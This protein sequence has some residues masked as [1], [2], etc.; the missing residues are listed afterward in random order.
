MKLRILP[1]AKQDLRRGFRFYE[2]KEEGVGSY[3]LDTAYSDIDSIGL[4]AG[5]H[6]KVGVLF[7]FKSKRFPFWIYYRRLTLHTWLPYL[8]RVKRPGRSGDERRSNKSVD[9]TGARHS[10]YGVTGNVAVVSAGWSPLP[11]PV[12]HFY[13][14]PTER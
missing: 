10:A 14:S 7:R 13:R 1:S 11:A 2:H 5:I 4:F 3:F 12:A 6:K 9:P 8:M